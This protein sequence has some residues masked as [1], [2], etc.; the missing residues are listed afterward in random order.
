M[1]IIERLMARA[2]RPGVR[3]VAL[4]VALIIAVI[5]AGYL[6][7]ANLLLQTRTIRDLVSAA[8]NVELSYESA[9]SLW[10]GRVNFERLALV[11]DITTCS[12]P[13][14]WT[15]VAST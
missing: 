6:G 3:V 13:S 10:P 4:R 14:M 11:A 1:R 8:R 9:Y 7:V 2:A 5:S 15:P 12:L